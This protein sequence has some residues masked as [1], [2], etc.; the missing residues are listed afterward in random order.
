M[1]KPIKQPPPLRQD[2]EAARFTLRGY[3]RDIVIVRLRE[4]ANGNWSI[5]LRRYFDSAGTLMPSQWALQLPIN[6]FPDLAKAVDRLGAE[7]K[8]RCP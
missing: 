2:I 8:E 7:I 6:A 3:D 4:H 5:D 1:Q